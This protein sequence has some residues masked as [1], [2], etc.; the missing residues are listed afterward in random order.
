MN[1][2]SIREKSKIF[3]WVCLI[4]FILSL[5]G[6]MGS[7]TGGGGGFLGGA[8][9]TSFFSNSVNPASHVGKIGEKNISRNFFAREVAK[10]RS[11]SQ[12]Q[13]NA[14][15]SFYIG[16]AWESIISNT[17]IT[18]QVTKLNLETHDS[19]LKNFLTNFPPSSLRDF[20]ASSK[21]FVD[22]DG[23][24]DLTAYQN[25]IN[26]GLEWIPDSLSNVFS[27]YESQLK[28][29]DL[30]RAKLQNL[31]SKLTS[32]SDNQIKSQFKRDNLNCNIDVLVVN[33]AEISDDQIAISEE[34]ISD[35]YNLHKEDKF[36]IPESVTLEYVLFENLEDENDSLEVVLNDEQKL[37]AED[38]AFDARE[39]MMGFDAALEAHELSITGTIDITE[40][41]NNNSGIPVNMGYNRNIVR[42]AFDNPINSVT[43]RIITKNGIAIFKIK[44]KND[45]NYKN[46]I[47][48]TDE[49]KDDI[50]LTKKEEFALNVLN[51]SYQDLSNWTN[52]S[53]EYNYITI[54]KN[55]E[56][57]IGGSFKS[58]G[59]N[60]KIMGCLSSMKEND[61]SKI[62]NSNDKLFVIKLN[63]IDSFDE[64]QFD[65]DYSSIRDR[66]INNSSRNLF[67][68]WIQYVSNNIKKIDVRHK[69]I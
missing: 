13:I 36:S 58:I 59:K 64:E 37:L 12:F 19:E 47:D 15:E 42:F 41:F 33:L 40:K 8:S 16:R 17:I 67:N 11:T 49:I 25:A 7:G 46:I 31:Y 39:D 56:A 14:T 38:F 34:E 48:I 22:T 24:F 61:I 65:K 9:L 30:P 62:I 26:N 23:A 63:S 2:S 32:V 3:L 18:E 1:M 10:Q 27:N 69:S 57:T 29:N 4:G 44:Y 52:L 6:V 60:F 20:L 54:S 35:Y 28:R 55:E 21:L 50:L 53:E 45:S 51:N 43:D 5:V 68:D 66:I